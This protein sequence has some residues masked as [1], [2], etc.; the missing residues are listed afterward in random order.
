MPTLEV[1]ESGIVI[2]EMKVASRDVGAFFNCLAEGERQAALDRVIQV[3]VFCLERAQSAQDLEFV[4]RQVEGLLSSVQTSV[5]GLPSTIEKALVAR[6]G[7]ESG[8]VLAP[9]KALVEQA[10][11]S[12]SSRINEVQGLLANEID[13]GKDSSTLGRALAT[14]RALLDPQRTDSVQGKLEAAVRSVAGK[15]GSL[16]VTVAAAVEKTLEPLVA[17]IT[18]LSHQVT[19]QKA[20]EDALA[21][22]TAKGATFEE[23]VVGTL[24]TW[25]RL[26]GAEVHYVGPENQPGDVVIRLST[27]AS[28]EARDITIVVEARDRQTPMG[29]KQIQD[30]ISQAMA[31]RKADAGLYIS[32]TSDGLGKEI[33]DWAEGQAE[34]GPWVATVREHLVVAVRFLL[35]RVQLA[36]MLATRAMPDLS[37][38]RSALQ[39]ISIS[40]SRI[41]TINRKTTV[42][43]TTADEIQTE[44]EQ[45]RDD[46]K[47]ALTEIEERL[48]LQPG[49]T[50]ASSAA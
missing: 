13:P 14:L 11:T 32:G 3:G 25:A 28:P 47:S 40:L 15:D 38:A 43:R 21:Q 46:I 29:R 26:S 10:S 19:A 12:T 44:A 6:L 17:S 27:T 2:R 48:R 37:S 8:Q 24:Q 34:C 4:R 31:Y 39:R 16:A 18:A 41:S 7:T 20:A 22:T 45:L 9:V 50:Q 33:G 1:S 42:V 49:A 35:G 23:E 5:A 36:R 30:Y